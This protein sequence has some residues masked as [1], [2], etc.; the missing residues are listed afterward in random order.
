MNGIRITG[1][2]AKGDYSNSV[3]SINI[4]NEMFFAQGDACIIL[5]GASGVQIDNISCEYPKFFGILFAGKGNQLSYRVK[6]SNSRF[7][8]SDASTHFN[9]G[10]TH[11]SF[12]TGCK[13][14]SVVN[15]EFQKTRTSDIFVGPGADVAGLQISINKFLGFQQGPCPG[16]AAS[17][18]L[19]GSNTDP[20]QLDANEWWEPATQAV[21]STQPIMATNN[22]CHAPF[23]HGT[24][25]NPL[26]K[27]CI[28]LSGAGA[29]GSYVEGNITDSTTY[30][31]V[32][33]SGG[34][35][36]LFSGN[37]HSLSPTGD[38]MVNM[39]SGSTCTTFSERWSDAAGNTA[40]CPRPAR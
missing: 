24:A 13:Y 19:A 37:N 14:C 15:T 1:S 32:G 17:V 9:G 2:T 40:N 30:A 11:I 38:V 3:H 10:Q 8:A 6:V 33:A 7:L 26:D 28:A 25:A 35:T 22:K 29:S 39:G 31:I 4:S 23:S 18:R 34:V 21:F 16:C 27:V 5:D 12:R 36:S 20:I